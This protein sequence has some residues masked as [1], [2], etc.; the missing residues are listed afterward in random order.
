[1]GQVTTLS[2]NLALIFLQTTLFGV[3]TIMI[4]APNLLQNLHRR[5]QHAGAY[6]YAEGGV[7]L[8]LPKMIS[9]G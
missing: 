2:G 7:Q 1:M 3:G 8:A 5:T 9:L 4:F 6:V